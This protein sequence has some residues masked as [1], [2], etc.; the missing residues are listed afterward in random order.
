MPF[1]IPNAGDTTGGNTYAALDQAEPDSLDFEILGNYASGV[2]SGCAVSPAGAAV[3]VTAGVVILRGVPYAV[4]DV[5]SLALTTTANSHFDI[6][7]ARVSNAIAAVTVVSGADSATNPTYPRSTSIS[8]SGTLNPDTDVVLAAVLRIGSGSPTTKNIVDKRTLLSSSIPDQGTGAPAA[9]RPEGPGSLYYQTGVGIGGTTSS[10]VWVKTGPGN[11]AWVELAQNIP[12]LSPI[13]VMGVWPSLQAPPSGWLL[14]DGRTLSTSTYSALF[15]VLSTSWNLAGD[16]NPALFRIPDMNHK[17]LRGT[18]VGGEIGT[19]I[20]ADS[21]VPPLPVHTHT[22]GSHT[23]TFAHSHNLVTSGGSGST[24]VQ[25]SHMHTFSNNPT[26]VV[27]V[28]VLLACAGPSTYAL[29]GSGS[30]VLYATA[31]VQPQIID[32]AGS[33]AHNVSIGA[34]TGSTS[35]QSASTT[36]GP[37]PTTI[38]NAGVGGS[39][40]TIPASVHA[41][42]II[43]ASLG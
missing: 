1:L 17:F 37:S 33:H 7:I 25:G 29:A 11:A 19:S 39:M 5:P 16:T 43:R 6:V 21:G 42:W 4:A 40:A 23:H 24:D 18:T 26:P 10:G 34:L 38:D 41:S 35:S 20:G 8:G 22:L 32:P 13:G 28:G 30:P 12:A 15:T 2:F 36:S 31:T 27:S 3:H 14:C 9:S